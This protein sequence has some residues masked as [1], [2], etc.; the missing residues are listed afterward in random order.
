MAEP[1]K[2]VLP[3][4][5]TITDVEPLVPDPCEHPGCPKIAAWEVQCSEYVAGCYR[6]GENFR[7]PRR[8]FCEEHLPDKARAFV[9]EAV[10]V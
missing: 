3:S 7:F 10:D 2:T 6:E 9:Q 1:T 4:H 5:W 8:Y